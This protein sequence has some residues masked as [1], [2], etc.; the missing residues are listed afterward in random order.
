MLRCRPLKIPTAHLGHAVHLL[1]I[2]ANSPLTATKK[3]NPKDPK[4]QYEEYK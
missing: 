1:N 2:E 4:T 3:E